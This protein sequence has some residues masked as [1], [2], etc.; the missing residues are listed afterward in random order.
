MVDGERSASFVTSLWLMALWKDIGICSWEIYGMGR[1]CLLLRINQLS[2]TRKDIITSAPLPWMSEV[3]MGIK[4]NTLD[5]QYK[6]IKRLCREYLAEAEQ[7]S[8]DYGQIAMDIAESMIKYL[9]MK[10]EL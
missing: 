10:G 3:S 5:R 2:T 4:I 7:D 9:S 6:K 8:P 1:K